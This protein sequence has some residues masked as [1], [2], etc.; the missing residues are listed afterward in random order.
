MNTTKTK[1]TREKARQSV[2][3]QC[4]RIRRGWTDS[5]RK[6]RRLSADVIQNQL[7]LTVLL[8]GGQSGSPS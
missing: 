4:A 2:A 6:L 3:N 1:S 5:E 8:R 7:L